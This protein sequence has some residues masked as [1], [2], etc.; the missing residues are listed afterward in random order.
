MNA[1]AHRIRRRLH[2][3][4]FQMV[5]TLE[6]RT[7]LSS[8]GGV[9]LGTPVNTA[10]APNNMSPVLVNSADFT[11]NNKDDVYVANS[12]DTVSV[13]L[14][15]G[16]GSFQTPV[17]S[18]AVAGE[19]LPLATGHFTGS[20]NLDIVTGT[21]G[22]SGAAGDVSILLG[23]GDGTF[24]S[25]INIPALQSNTALAVGNFVTSG[26]LDVVSVDNAPNGTGAISNICVTITDGT[27]HMAS[28]HFYTVDG[29]VTSIAVGDFGNA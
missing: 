22:A 16:D 12:N 6:S 20:G 28:Q 4:A 1:H 13:L 21:T 10:A 23:N 3:A 18:Y 11:N 7:L 15:N 29:T 2:A 19:P 27:G 17:N 14:S 26:P 9:V 24:Q 8:I 25:A 5:E